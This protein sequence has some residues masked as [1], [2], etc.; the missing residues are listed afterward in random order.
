MRL[1]GRAPSSWFLRTLLRLGF[2]LVGAGL[3]MLPSTHWWHRHFSPRYEVVEIR[4]RDHLGPLGFNSRFPVERLT[5]YR[6]GA[7]QGLD[8]PL[9]VVEYRNEDGRVEHAML[10]PEW[11][12]ASLS[13]ASNPRMDLWATASQSIMKHASSDS[14]YL[15]WWDNAQR[16]HFLTGEATWPRLPAAASFMDPFAD[17]WK[18]AAGQYAED[19]ESARQLAQWLVM[20]AESALKDIR[21]KV[22]KPKSIYILACVDDLARLGEIERLSGVSIPLEA[23]YFPASSDLHAQIKEVRSWASEKGEGTNY[24]V[25]PV[26]G[27][28]VR[29]WRVTHPEA[30]N[31]LL[32]RLLPFS[33]SLETPLEGAKLVYQSLWGAYI[34]VH[35]VTSA[36]P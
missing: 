10:Y 36:A 24:L 26:M 33:K 4:D 21:F 29:A 35:E 32:I 8:V 16:I 2:L 20:D 34:S 9:S 12:Q 31:L 3:W 7:N 5:L 25:Q 30:S 18:K 13:S 27:G 17:F 1:E 22:Q 14:L 28:G 19:S 6:V 23:K 15:A 11:K